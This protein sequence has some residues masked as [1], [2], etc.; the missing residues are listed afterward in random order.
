MRD[1]WLL[2][3]ALLTAAACGDDATPVPDGGVDAGPAPDGGPARD[4]GVDAGPPPP[5]DA[6]YKE[7]WT[8]RPTTT[9][10][11][12]RWESQLPPAVVAVEIEPEAGGVPTM[13]TGSSRETVVTLEHG[14]DSAIIDEPDLPG[15]YSV[16]EVDVTGLEPATCYLYRLSGWP[17]IGGRFCTLH[18][19]TDHDTP[20][21]FYVVGDTNPV[22][23][24]TARIFASQDPRQAEIVLHAGDIQYYS[25][26]IE[27]YQVW[28]RLMRP[29]LS[30]AAFMPCVG[31][32][33]S[34]LDT[35][36]EDYYVRL[37]AQ[38]AEP[39]DDIRYTFAT[40]GVHVFSISTEHDL[41]PGSE[42][43]AWLE[44]RLGRAEATEGFRFSI[45]LFHRP[46]YS[47]GDYRPRLDDRAALEPLL[48]AHR[49][50]LVL[51]GHLHGYERFEVG[52]VTYITS[53]GGGTIPDDVNALVEE[54][55]E[56]A[57]L[58]VVA[59]AWSQSVLIEIVGDRITGEVIDS[60]GMVRDSFEKTVAP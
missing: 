56:D 36:F 59:G 58:R 34:E 15:T 16:N 13:A 7:P 10:A 54:L 18:E 60:T 19:P 22:L 21:R 9:G 40:G 32:H 49:V 37:F 17:E 41:S 2:L 57:A 30:A 24:V 53:G 39:G 55:P 52:D 33:E 29:L 11:T 23:D 12:V 8:V 5:T 45:V 1:P 31:N 50:P 46:I 48:D 3:L 35:E 42:Q 25:A 47:V 43:H 26:V 27:T 44:D 14:R 4:A 38:G 51:S 20:I 6:P 28:W